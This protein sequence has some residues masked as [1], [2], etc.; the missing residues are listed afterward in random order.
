MQGSK[1]ASEQTIEHH[2]SS[3]FG[4]AELTTKR[5]Q[6]S[7]QYEEY[8]IMPVARMAV[9]F[10]RESAGAPTVASPGRSLL[11]SLVYNHSILFLSI[12]LSREANAEDPIRNK[13]SHHVAE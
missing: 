11:V 9:A 10:W 1:Q 6:S 5:K 12:I 2:P 4:N 7:I 13:I 8:Y 3:F